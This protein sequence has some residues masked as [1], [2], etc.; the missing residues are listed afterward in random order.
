MRLQSNRNDE[1]LEHLGDTTQAVWG[2]VL[3]LSFVFTLE[4]TVGVRRADF[5]QSVKLQ[6]GHV[7][8]KMSEPTGTLG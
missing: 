6:N 1:Y 2:Q 3:L 4:S 7:D 5:F 8:Q